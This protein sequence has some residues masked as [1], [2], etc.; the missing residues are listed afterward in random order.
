[1]WVVVWIGGEREEEE[2]IP[3]SRLARETTYPTA[4]CLVQIPLARGLYLA[5]GARCGG[6][7]FSFPC[8]RF[9][10][11]RDHHHHCWKKAREVGTH[12]LAPVLF[13]VLVTSSRNVGSW[14]T[15]KCFLSMGPRVL[16]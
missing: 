5:G 12:L 9:E 4:L 2:N 13:N 3:Q 10:R 8:A 1:M 6:D 14:E 7:G 11:A 15:Q 16:L